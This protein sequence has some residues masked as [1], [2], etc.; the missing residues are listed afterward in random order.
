MTAIVGIA[1]DGKVYIA[2][3]SAG[4][5]DLDVTVRED[6]KI[7]QNGNMIFGYTSSFRMGQLL[8]FKLKI[9]KQKCDN[10]L[11]YMV[12]DFIDA[13]KSCFKKN[14]YSKIENNTE[15]G[16]CFMVGYKS[17][18]Y[19]IY[20]DFQVGKSKIQYDAIGCGEK[21]CLGSMYSTSNEKDPK[22]RLITALESAEKF[23]GGVRNPF[24]IISL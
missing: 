16:G 21:Y 5:S 8:R 20:D 9:P 14:G 6:T 7:F 24:N 11:E 15:S 12:T 2:G 23:S 17:A 22:K 19:V 10:D 3:D 1:K 13:V 4:V 18:L